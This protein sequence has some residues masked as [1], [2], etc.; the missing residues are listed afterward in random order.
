MTDYQTGIPAGCVVGPTVPEEEGRIALDIWARLLDEKSM[1]PTG[2]LRRIR[3]RTLG[4][5]YTDLH[6]ALKVQVCDKCSEERTTPSRYPQC[7]GGN[8]AGCGGQWCEI[9]DEYIAGP[10]DQER[11]NPVP[12]D[13][14]WIA[15][16]PVTGGS[17]GHYVHIDFV[18]RGEGLGEKATL[19]RLALIKTFKGK[20]YAF[21]LARRCT[22][23]LG[24]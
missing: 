7:Y 24:A 3:M 14:A 22:D 4:E 18:R 8:H 11:N 2:T 9:I 20:G 6:T 12:R 15:C 5:V 17:E 16:F 21:R 1:Q 23:L 13:F 19:T 10:D